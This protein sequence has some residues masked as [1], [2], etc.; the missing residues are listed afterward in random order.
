MKPPNTEHQRRPL[1][2]VVRLH[3]Q[4]GPRMRIIGRVGSNDL[5]KRDSTSSS[6]RL[7]KVSRRPFSL[8]ASASAPRPATE[9]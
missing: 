3:D 5:L 2:A 9:L 4:Q 8:T 7:E 6:A 1:H